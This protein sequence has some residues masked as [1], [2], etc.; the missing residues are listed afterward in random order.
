LFLKY[1]TSPEVQAKWAKVSNY[2]PVRASVAADM[3]DYF[4][5]N[6]AYKTAWDMLKYGVTEPP[7]PGYDFVRDMVRENM[8][9]IVDGADVQ[10]TLDELTTEAN[11]NLADQMEQIQ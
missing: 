7:V 1:Y 2:F 11:A 9:A 3:T 10:A 5:A 4:D 6:P 8:A